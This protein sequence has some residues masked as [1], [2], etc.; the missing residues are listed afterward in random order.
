MT[1]THCSLSRTTFKYDDLIERIYFLG[2]VIQ[3]LLDS[4]Y[5]PQ[6]K[7]ICKIIPLN[8]FAY[9]TFPEPY[10]LFKVS[11]ANFFIFFVLFKSVL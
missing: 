4:T 2:Q 6:R 11:P 1:K 5:C 8:L 10:G 3:I 7:E 9:L